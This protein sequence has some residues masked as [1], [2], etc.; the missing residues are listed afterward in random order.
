MWAEVLGFVTDLPGAAGE[1]AEPWSEAGGFTLTTLLR[2]RT[3]LNT[4]PL[5][6]S[7]FRC[8]FWW[9]RKGAEGRL[10]CV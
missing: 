3:G 2:G 9:L 8:F 7:E 1:G 4:E 10:G 6:L 5:S